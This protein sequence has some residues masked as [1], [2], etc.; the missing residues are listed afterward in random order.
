M[1]TACGG[2][3]GNV[4]DTTPPV[5]TLNGDTNITMMQDGMYIDLSA[6][7]VD[8]RDGNVPVT[9]KGSVDAS[10]LGRQTIEYSA[11]DSSG[12]TA[13]KIRTIEVV[14]ADSLLKKMRDR[15]NDDTVPYTTNAD[16]NKSEYAKNHM[17][18]DQ[19]RR[20]SRAHTLVA[21]AVDP[22]PEWFSTH[23]DKP[24]SMS[25]AG[26][27]YT[28]L[29]NKQRQ[30]GSII[31][32]VD[33]NKLRFVVR[34]QRG[35]DN[36]E[37]VTQNDVDR[38]ASWSADGVL[39]VH[40]P[41]DLVQ[42]RLLI[43][44]RPNFDDVSTS[45]IAERWSTVITA[46]VAQ[47]KSGVKVV[48][49][50][51]IVFPLEGAS[52]PTFAQGS[53]FTK[54]EIANKVTQYF[55]DNQ[56]L[57]LPIV[58]K[59]MH[60]KEGDLLSYLFKNR[61]YSGKVIYVKTRNNQQ[62][63]LITL[64]FFKVY[65]IT[66]S[67]DKFMVKEGLYPENV[68][69]REGDTVSS[70]NNESDMTR[71]S[72]RT[73]KISVKDLFERKC[74]LSKATLTYDFGFNISPLEAYVNIT[75]HIDKPNTGCTWTAKS[76]GININKMFLAA[77]PLG[78]A[79]Q[80]VG[81][82]INIKPVGKLTVMGKASLPMGATLGISTKGLTN[83]I[84]FGYADG[85]GSR[86][87]EGEAVSGQFDLL[88]ETGIEASL[89]AVSSNGFIG[90]V[91][92]FLDV[93]ITQLGIV[94]AAKVKGGLTFT[95]NNARQVS[96]TDKSSG[97]SFVPSGEVSIK[98]TD[99][100]VKF[101]KYFVSD[102]H[103]EAKAVIKSEMKVD[104]SFSYREVD[105]D[106]MGEA[107][108][109]GLSFD[110]YYLKKLFAGTESIGVLAPVNS[111]SSTY[112]DLTEVISYDI[113]ECP[114]PGS[115]FEDSKLKVPAIGCFG[116]I[117]GKFKK[118]VELCA[119]IKVPP[120]VASAKVGEEATTTI[121]IKNRDKE[122]SV[123]L[124][125]TPLE[126]KEKT[127]TIPE[128]GERSVQ[129]TKTCPGEPGVQ[130]E[131]TK[132]KA[133]DGT[134]L[135]TADNILVCHDDDV[136]GDPHIVTA[137][138][139]GYDYYASGDYI[140]SRINGVDGFEVQARFLP[141][142]ETSWPQAVALNVGGDRVEIH[143]TSPGGHGGGAGVKINALSIWVNGERRYVGTSR[144]WGEKPSSNY[145]TLPSGG[146]LA[147]T[148]TTS[149]N[150]L[151][152]PSSLTVVWPKESQTNAYGVILSVASAGQ[153]FVQIQIARPDTFSGEERGLMGNNDGDPTN[154]FIRRNG[155]VLASDHNLS[156]TEL[157]GL[158]GADW[159]VRPYE[160]LFRNPE[161]IKAE[162]PKGIVTLTP[163]Q[164]A[165]GEEACA[166]LTGFYR[167]ACIIDVGLTG[168]T[169]MV[170]EYYADTEDLNGLSDAIRTPIAN[171]PHY[172]LEDKG[173]VYEDN[174]NY[175]QQHY[176]QKIKISHVSGTGNFMLLVR[177]PRGAKAILGTGNASYTSH[178]NFETD[179]SVDCTELNDATNLAFLS[180]TGSVQLWLQDPLS[181]A[182]AKMV[183]EIALPCRDESE[184][185]QYTIKLGSKTEFADSNKSNQHY[186]Q[187]IDI[188]QLST[189][190]GKY[191]LVAIPPK[192]GSIVL[193]S[194]GNEFNA[195]GEQTN[196]VALNCVDYN[197]DTDILEYGKN[198]YLELWEIHPLT[199]AKAS[200]Y[201]KTLLLCAKENYTIFVAES[202]ET[203]TSDIP[204]FEFNKYPLLDRSKLYLYN[205]KYF[206]RG[207][208]AD[209]IQKTVISYDLSGF[210]EDRNI[211]DLFDKTI[212]Y[213]ADDGNIAYTYLY[214]PRLYN[215]VKDQNFLY[216]PTLPE[217]KESKSHSRFIKY[218]LVNEEIVYHADRDPQYKE[219]HRGTFDLAQGWFMPL[220][221]Q[222]LSVVQTGQQ[223]T[224][225]IINTSDGLPVQY[226]GYDYYTANSL[227]S[228]IT[229][230]ESIPV[231]NNERYFYVD[232]TEVLGGE[233]GYH[234]F[235]VKLLE[236]SENVHNGERDINL[237]QHSNEYNNPNYRVD[238]IIN[239]FKEKYTGDHNYTLYSGFG[240]PLPGL[241]LD[242]DK[243]WMLLPVVYETGTTHLGAPN[244]IIDLYLV[245]Y[246]MSSEI[247]NIT[248]VESSKE[249]WAPSMYVSKP[250]KYKDVIYYIYGEGL[251]DHV[252]HAY[253]VN[254][255]TFVFKKDIAHEI[256]TN[257]IGFS[258]DY[259]LTGDT[260]V[261]PQQ[262]NDKTDR[263]NYNYNIVFDVLDIHTGELI[264]RIEHDALRLF[265]IDNS[266]SLDAIVS[267]R[268]TI[269]FTMTKSFKEGSKRVQHQM[270]IKMVSF[271]NKV[272][273][274]G[275]GYS[276]QMR[277]VIHDD[278]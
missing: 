63:A 104:A 202:N 116:W 30:D 105:D 201:K 115:V 135:D 55:K 162:F 87:L 195:T 117:C 247:Q 17:P 76:K 49:E 184:I 269:Y 100:I 84:N 159:L 71:F 11:T 79:A 128:A 163:E 259:I 236:D 210:D 32:P 200:L 198:G 150:V 13:T 248:L 149:S 258:Y 118:E 127:I 270:I 34:I 65:D 147:V 60:I 228:A 207:S 101:F 194:G 26:D 25:G 81:M 204:V 180:Y 126:P 155:Q 74:F 222:Q 39:D 168:S 77:G 174:S 110:S 261:V 119:E 178:G 199:G 275:E 211:S 235:N 36:F 151:T 227:S 157:Y 70:D 47:L 108:V 129:F 276:M 206:V 27:S 205:E 263:H 139:L 114:D 189:N 154:D 203:N 50:S 141:G 3:G 232:F 265:N 218:D 48:D 186:S 9:K 123:E 78:W 16:F 29:L 166:A 187:E 153:P 238:N 156:F 1:I 57:A 2:G 5:I 120:V 267:D 93:K 224:L 131:E 121:T 191:S 31:G 106:G 226:D 179:V 271:D 243:L 219:G 272:E 23:V 212:Y 4:A 252:L 88:T 255:N 12:N 18:E 44:I 257:N 28:V 229:H 216:F 277:R 61:P 144:D 99:A 19:S 196:S 85:L 161:A 38:Y 66:D 59:N 102:I 188:K 112:N 262:I 103:L 35:K 21:S 171:L 42:G 217:S 67:S 6:K 182:A 254:T 225:S 167:E 133:H 125:G 109:Q 192:G 214:N 56:N 134:I 220:E 33:N 175:L 75:G 245:E 69:Y 43:G 249:S 256:N 165:L 145:L 51:T 142:F 234:L 213:Q 140:L 251:H 136:R 253:N 80:A 160:S 177:P 58:V 230:Y 107:S 164:R 98:P 231:V 73:K 37:Y 244:K 40:V 266:V 89:N 223:G 52:D 250:Y 90:Y 181:G 64:E 221:N 241:M 46:E 41:D 148:K 143:G 208:R 53:K 237:A 233:Y 45:A 274:E 137:D 260:I 273:K 183:S 24:F 146:L 14:T 111:F 176:K 20:L 264:K 215:M 190:I 95:M 72:K 15:L 172:E 91:L 94:A 209:N 240:I 68:I 138:K 170:R 169:D 278:N 185:P 82:G 113:G 152:Y 122:I 10:V 197:E 246:N 8:D 193:G 7:A 173:K 97:I 132:L 92:D 54:V 242:N 239:D 158:F 86:D 96:D 22:D 130:R 83:K 268:D 124:D 62:F